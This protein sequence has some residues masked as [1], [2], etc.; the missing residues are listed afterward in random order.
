MKP[1]SRFALVGHTAL[2]FATVVLASSLLIGSAGAVVP[3]SDA[4]AT[5]A[6]TA[7]KWVPRKIHF[8]YSAVSTSSVSTYYS[9]DSLEGQIKAILREL[10]ARDEVV[11]TFGCMTNGGP[12]RFPGVDATFSVLEPAGSGDQGAAGSKNVE[13]HWDKVTL[14]PDTSCELIEQVKR[15]ILPL[16]ATRNQASGCSP[17]FSVEVLQPVKSPVTAS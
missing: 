11:K 5:V 7:A 8:M 1:F 3:A 14:K 6:P 9:C 15:Q 4:Q 2:R 10:G 12:E 13:A 17:R 16:F